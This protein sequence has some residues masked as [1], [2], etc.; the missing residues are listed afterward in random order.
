MRLT[1]TAFSRVMFSTR[2]PS[3]VAA[4]AGSRTNANEDAPASAARRN[5]RRVDAVV[6]NGSE[7]RL[8][9]PPGSP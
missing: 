9:H 8:K 4:V 2:K 6:V 3:G 1:R 7:R 5:W